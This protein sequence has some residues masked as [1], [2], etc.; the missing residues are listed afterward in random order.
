MLKTHAKEDIK[1][2]TNTAITRYAWSDG[3]KKVSIYI[4]LEGIGG[5]H[6]DAIRLDWTNDSIELMI[7]DF[8]SSNHLLKLPLYD[9][10]EEASLRKKANKLVVTMKKEKEISWHQLKKTST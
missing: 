10:I 9:M 4:E 2:A 6:D 3:K 5:H 7:R 8:Q 1:T